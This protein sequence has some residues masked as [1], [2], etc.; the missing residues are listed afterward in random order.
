MRQI[1]SQAI[2]SLKVI[3]GI[4]ILPLER[5]GKKQC[6]QRKKRSQSV[7]SF[8][9]TQI[10]EA[11]IM[12]GKQV[13]RIKRRRALLEKQDRERLHEIS[14]LH[15]QR[16]EEENLLKTAKPAGQSGSAAMDSAGDIAGIT[17]F[18]TVISDCLQS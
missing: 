15:R 5:R 6:D 1:L 3:N 18:C 2:P 4:D 14:Q 9:K 10:P 16:T 13:T 12:I 17:G 7:L 8:L 11:D